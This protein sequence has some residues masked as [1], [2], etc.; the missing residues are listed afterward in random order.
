MKRD[1]FIGDSGQELFKGKGC[2]R[3]SGLPDAAYVKGWHDVNKS[4]DMILMGVGGDND[5]QPV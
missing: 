4:G 3:G 2:I 5:I 1:A